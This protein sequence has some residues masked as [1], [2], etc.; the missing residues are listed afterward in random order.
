MALSLFIAFFAGLVSFFSPCVLPL[1]PGYVSFICGATLA[2]L[3]SQSK[4]YILKRSLIFSL[5]FSL[6]FVCL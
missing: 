2:E 4:N 3:K 6:V 1:I 5:G